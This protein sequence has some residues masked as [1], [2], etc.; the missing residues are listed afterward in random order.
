MQQSETI[1]DRTLVEA[2][3]YMSLPKGWT[4]AKMIREAHESGNR[5]RAIIRSQGALM[6]GPKEA[7]HLTSLIGYLAKHAV[8]HREAVIESSSK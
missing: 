2:I 4:H 3:D 6:I 5:I 1:E 8:A 7:E